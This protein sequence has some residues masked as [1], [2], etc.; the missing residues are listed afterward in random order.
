DIGRVV[1]WRLDR[2]SRDT[3]DFMQTLKFMRENGCEIA[4]VNE[5][6][7]T[8]TPM[9]RAMVGILAVFAQLE[10]ETIGERV[11]DNMIQAVRQKKI[12]LGAHP[13][14]GYTRH[15][16]KLTVH[17]EQAEIVR[18]IFDRYIAGDGT[19]RIAVELT[20]RGIP[21]PLGRRIWRYNSIQAIL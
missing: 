13:P 11:R 21:T 7:D 1:V 3:A 12:H 14:Y 17:P 16:G 8:S 4:S 9:G 2:F 6:F 18:W 10:S 20:E 5:S 19:R 15:K